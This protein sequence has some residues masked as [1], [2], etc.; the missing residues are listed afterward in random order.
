M[1][2]ASTI[3]ASTLTRPESGFASSTR[4]SASMRT[5]TSSV[6]A[7]SVKECPEPATC[8]VRPPAAASRTAAASSSR[9]RGRSIAA[10]SQVWSPA[11]LRQLLAPVAAGRVAVV[12]IG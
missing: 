11:Q 3:P 7:A 12:A 4:F 9:L 2:S 5:I 6:I 1:R 8:T 10:G